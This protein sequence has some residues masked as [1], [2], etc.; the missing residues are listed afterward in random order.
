[1]TLTRRDQLALQTPLE[2]LTF[3]DMASA[4][5]YMGEPDPGND[6]VAIL[7]FGMRLRARLRHEMAEAMLQ[8]AARYET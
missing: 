8:E 1:M 5:E 7:Q 2:G 4:A 3:P 6:P